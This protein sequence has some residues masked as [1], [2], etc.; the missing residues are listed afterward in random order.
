[1]FP[2]Q[3]NVSMIVGP[4]GNTTVQAGKEGIVVVDTQTAAAAPQVMAAIRKIS[5]SPDHLDDQHQPGCGSHG[6]KRSPDPA[7]R[8][9]RRER[10]GS[11]GHA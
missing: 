6:R 3:G 11:R 1:M 8:I 2:V 5:D 9:D 7:G 4:G 10:A